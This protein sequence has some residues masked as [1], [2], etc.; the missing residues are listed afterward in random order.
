MVWINQGLYFLMRGVVS[1]H[2]R[3]MGLW[4]CLVGIKLNM[5]LGGANTA[6]KWEH[7]RVAKQLS[8]EAS[9][10]REKLMR[11]KSEYGRIPK[12]S[13]SRG[14]FNPPVKSLCSLID[15]C[16]Q[17]QTLHQSYQC[18]QPAL[19]HQ[20]LAMD[21]G[22]VEMD[23]YTPS[24]LFPIHLKKHTTSK[25]CSWARGWCWSILATAEG[26]KVG[27]WGWIRKKSWKLRSPPSE[28]TPKQKTE[29]CC[30]MG[31]YFETKVV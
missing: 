26:P 29:A 15:F 21:G 23:K 4:L 25:A 16:W 9:S 14:L 28:K 3:R 12:K 20:L 17:N 31:S 24:S 13:D 8:E 11:Q 5:G 10:T 1:G 19:R 30:K 27:K 6:K 18:I 7:L 2:E 22:Q